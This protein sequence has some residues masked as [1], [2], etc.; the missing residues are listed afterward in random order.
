ML[1]TQNGILQDIV[2]RIEEETTPSPTQFESSDHT[3]EMF[4][5]I[6][7]GQHAMM[8]KFSELTETQN[9]IEDLRGATDA[10]LESKSDWRDAAVDHRRASQIVDLQTQIRDE[11][12]K[13][14]RAE[15]DAAILS[16]RVDELNKHAKDKELDD[17]WRALIRADVAA[18][19]ASLS[20][21]ARSQDKAQ[22]DLDEMR[23]Q[24]LAQSTLAQ[25]VVDAQRTEV[26]D[27]GWAGADQAQRDTKNQ[28]AAERHAQLVGLQNDAAVFDQKLF[29]LLG[30]LGQAVSRNR[31]DKVQELEQEVKSLRSEVSSEY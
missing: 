6:I 14:H 17:V 30:G 19:T 12:T 2:R 10:L 9:A 26:G 21:V 13:T 27:S 4:R 18:V 11:V 7:S 29:D 5:A 25:S 3:Q 1:E 15:R 16:I 24:L 23:E 8:A 22:D 31:D 20:K 28:L